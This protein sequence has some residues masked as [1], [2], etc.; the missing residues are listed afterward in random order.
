MKYI[1]LFKNDAEYQAF[2]GGDYITPNLCLNSET[3][4][5]KCEPEEV[6]PNEITFIVGSKDIPEP[7]SITADEKIYT[8]VEG[9]S[10]GEFINSK[11]NVDKWYVDGNN[12]VVNQYNSYIQNCDTSGVRVKASHIIVNNGYYYWA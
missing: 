11:Y 10:F 3:W 8:A 4:E 12:R 1:K 2:K 6:V 5:T 7:G 9:M